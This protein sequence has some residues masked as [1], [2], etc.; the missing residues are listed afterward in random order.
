MAVVTKDIQFEIDC[1]E[2]AL[3][4]MGAAIKNLKK[5]DSIAKATHEARRKLLLGSYQTV[6]EA[7]DAFGYGYITEN[8]Y[9]AIAEGLEA[10]YEKSVESAAYEILHD[11]AVR[12]KQEIKDFKWEALPQDEKDRIR[13]AN[14]EYK[15][16]LQALRTA[17]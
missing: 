5:A 15:A 4:K 16:G 13:R 2:L 3:T 17:K 1:R 6:E 8:E 11:F 14:D 7:H 10:P 9:R 12:L